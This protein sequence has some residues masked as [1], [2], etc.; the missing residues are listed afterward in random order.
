MLANCAAWIAEEAAYYNIPIEALTDGEAQGHGRGVCQHKQLGPAG[1]GHSD[2]GPNFPMQ[3]VLTMARGGSPAPP[4]PEDY[5][6][7]AAVV[8]SGGTLEV[9][10]EADDGSVWHT[11][12]KKN[13]TAWSGGEAGKRVAGLTKL[14]PPPGK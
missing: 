9:F 3:E 6:A 5:I 14:C 10:V 8:S 7:I 4:T 12:Q 11:W 2:C 1:G 13:E